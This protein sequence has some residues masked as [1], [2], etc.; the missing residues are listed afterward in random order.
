[1][2]VLAG[3]RFA[4]VLTWFFL[5][6][7]LATK[8]GVRRKL[9]LEDG[10]AVG[11]QRTAV[12]VAANGLGGTAA[13]LAYLWATDAGAD[14][15]LCPSTAAAPL[16]ARLLCAF[17][18]HYA[19]CCGDTWASELGVLARGQPVLIT[20]GRRVRRPHK[21]ASGAA[22]HR[23][24]SVGLDGVRAGAGGYKRCR[25]APGNCCKRTWG[26]DHG[27]GGVCGD[28][29]APP[30]RRQRVCPPA[31]G[32]GCAGHGRGRGR[33]HGTVPRAPAPLL[34]PPDGALTGT[35]VWVPGRLAAGRD[36]ASVVLVRA[37]AP[38]RRR[39]RRHHHSHVRMAVA[40]AAPVAP[41]IG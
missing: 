3:W 29:C 21:V 1:V 17:V 32:L 37:Q 38:R 7:S 26:P 9:A 16:A 27:P 28:G 8:V 5:S 25:V 24:P 39:A 11:G 22:T 13:A 14:T 41:A 33:V 4:A 12:Q 19:C 20:T 6:S 30:G 34:T 35:S 23:W 31:S 2:T 18:A 15:D 10:H 36:A 40:A